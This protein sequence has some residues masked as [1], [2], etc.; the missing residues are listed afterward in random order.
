MTS[1]IETQ[2]ADAMARLKSHINRA[3]GQHARAVKR[4]FAASQNRL[5]GTD[6]MRYE[7]TATGVVFVNPLKTTPTQPEV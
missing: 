6:G 2:C 7:R 4:A 5:H 3:A 1:A